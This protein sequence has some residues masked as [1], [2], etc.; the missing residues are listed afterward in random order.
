MKIG[1]LQKLSLID[2]PGRISA[3]VFTQGCNFRCSYCHNPELVD[4]ARFGAL[5]PEAETFAFLERRRGK[6]DAVTLSGGEP[7]L[8]P[9]LLP[10]AGRIRSM[11]FLVKV[12]TN[13]SR[14]DILEKLLDAG[15]VDYLAMDIK[16]PPDEYRRIAHSDIAAETIRRSIEVIMASG[17]AY[18]FRTTVVK[19]LLKAGDLSRIAA[20]VKTA[21][22][23][24]LQGFVPSKTLDARFLEESPFPRDELDRIRQDLEKEL[25]RVAIR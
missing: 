3:V 13:G 18:E 1:G 24:V 11:G 6:L 17:V 15:V 21:R 8:Q 16:G 20:S 9:D 12:D 25:P 4:P 19:S 23:F 2:Y 10:I 5:L 14:P 22:L 7:T